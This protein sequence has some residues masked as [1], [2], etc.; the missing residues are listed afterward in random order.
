MV[1]DE[2]LEV[3]ETIGARRCCREFVSASKG[4]GK[5][6]SMPGQPELPAM[7]NTMDGCKTLV[8]NLGRQPLLI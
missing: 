7:R 3:G 5:A 1:V 4:L 2:R 8:N 6:R